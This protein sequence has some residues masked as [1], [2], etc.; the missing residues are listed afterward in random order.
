MLKNITLSTDDKLLQKAREKALK[1]K[2]TLNMLFREWLEE[3]T[4][5][6]SNQL[7]YKELM[8]H[9]EHVKVGRK[10]SREELNER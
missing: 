9:L 8:K 3:Y 6:N 1:N 5:D 7:N 4:R 10:F 2:K